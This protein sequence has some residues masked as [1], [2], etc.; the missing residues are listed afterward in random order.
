MM[1][2]A[3]IAMVMGILILVASMAS[4]ELG[5][6]V[7]LIEIILGVVASN[8]FG[9]HTTP[10][11][12]FL[13]SFASIVLTFLAGAEVDPDVMQERLKESL[14]IGGISFLVPFLGA[15]MAAY[16]LFGWD[17]KAAQICGVALSTTS[18]AVVYAVLVETGL[19]HTTLGKII[20][21][22]TFVTD[23]GTALALSL[24][25]VRPTWWLV[26]FL[27]V[28]AG[29]IIVMPRLQPWF[30]SRYGGRVIE[31]EIKGAFAA[32][33]VLMYFAQRAESHA[34]LPAFV[35]GL[36]VARILQ[37]NRE[38]QRR[39]RVVAFALLTPFFFIKSGMNVSLTAV[40]ANLG[41]TAGLLAVKLLTKWVGVYP[42]ARRYLSE[43]ATYT[44]LL[45]STGLTF[46]TI[47]S[48][49][50]LNAGIITKDQFSVLVTVVVLSAVVPTW[51]A[52]RFFQPAPHSTDRGRASAGMAPG[53]A[54]PRAHKTSGEE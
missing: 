15:W 48:L 5:I 33:L 47:S 20:M 7:A 25:F 41:L 19:T 16:Y 44:T 43:G 52:Q 1:D 2:S 27:L 3:W 9:L 40:A 36:A 46:G 28:S 24:L 21:A 35:L 38:Q 37:A 6:S 49:Y 31:P 34:V 30:F 22:S 13:A 29:L 53:A 50:G 11:I 8:G 14:W 10:W 32:L 18:L 42:T 17:W 51:I 45:M 12:D 54:D 4:V 23:F 26:P 39:F